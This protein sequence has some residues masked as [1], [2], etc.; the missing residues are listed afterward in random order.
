[1]TARPQ[2]AS[3]S[4][5]R[6]VLLPETWGSGLLPFPGSGQTAAWALG[7]AKAGGVPPRDRAV[8]KMVLSLG[9]QDKR[10]P[11]TSSGTPRLLGKAPQL[12]VEITP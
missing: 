6:G 10:G 11:E 4:L 3:G 12:R 2:G 7:E 8:P 5:G 9:N 1:M